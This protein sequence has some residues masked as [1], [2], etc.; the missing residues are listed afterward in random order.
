MCISFNLDF[1]LISRLGSE[2][3][4]WTGESMNL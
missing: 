4:D 2:Y 3:G 1:E